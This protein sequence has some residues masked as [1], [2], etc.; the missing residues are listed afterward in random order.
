VIRNDNLHCL[1]CL[2]SK[3]FFI[4]R[5]ETDLDRYILSRRSRGRLVLLQDHGHVHDSIH[6]NALGVLRTYK[7]IIVSTRD[8]DSKKI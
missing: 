3:V 4:V 2:K 5:H 1:L 6:L 7:S 8:Q